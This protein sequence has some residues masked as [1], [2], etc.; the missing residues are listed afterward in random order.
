MK[1]KRGFVNFVEI[2]EKINWV[3]TVSFVVSSVEITK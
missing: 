3:E 1:L 2:Y